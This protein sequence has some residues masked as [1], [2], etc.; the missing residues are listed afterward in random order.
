LLLKV[1]S[2]EKVASAVE[3]LFADPALAA[4]LG[5]AARETILARFSQEI[6]VQRT[7]SLYEQL[8]AGHS[9]QLS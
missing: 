4:R 9:I 6:M 2:P 7:L 5:C 1:S 3:R 8:V